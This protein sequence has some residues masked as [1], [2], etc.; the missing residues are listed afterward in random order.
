MYTTRLQPVVLHFLSYTKCGWSIRHHQA[1][2]GGA[3]IS[4]PGDPTHE[5]AVA[6]KLKY[7]RLKPG[8]VVI[9]ALPVFSA[10]LNDHRLKAWVVSSTNTAR[11]AKNN[12]VINRLP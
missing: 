6:M 5:R 11:Q 8:G 4:Q 10:K 12:L 2:A 7:H 1:S 9:G 3:A